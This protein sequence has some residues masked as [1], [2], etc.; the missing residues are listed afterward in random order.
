MNIYSE[1]HSQISQ[2]LFRAALLACSAS[3]V[4]IVAFGNGTAIGAAI[5]VLICSCAVSLGLP[6]A[7]KN[8]CGC[9]STYNFTFNH[10]SQACDDCLK[11]SSIGSIFGAF[12]IFLS[13]VFVA[14]FIYA[15]TIRR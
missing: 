12:C 8:S 10:P 5:L 2:T 7:E 9:T 3:S 6:Y 14:I 1:Y 11:A 15:I 13:I 4:A